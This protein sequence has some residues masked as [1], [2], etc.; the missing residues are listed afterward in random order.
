MTIEQL[1]KRIKGVPLKPPEE[2]FWKDST[3]EVVLSLFLL[4][5]VTVTP[6]VVVYY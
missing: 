6:I 2:R 1:R 3:I 5:V 4:A